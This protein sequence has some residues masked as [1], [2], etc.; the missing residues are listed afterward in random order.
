MNDAAVP[1]A[2]RPVCPRC[3]TFALLR[4]RLGQPL[5]GDCIER[6]THDIER[7]PFPVGST[8][9]GAWQLVRLV[10]D[11][12]L[13][14][15]LAIHLP[16]IVSS[17]LVELPLRARGLFWI[18]ELV[19]TAAIVRMAL[20]A[21]RGSGREPITRSIGAAVV[22]WG[23]RLVG[24]SFVSALVSG[25]YLLLLVV[26]GVLKALSFALVP[27]C[28]VEERKTSA[29]ALERST[30]LMRG[31]RSIMF[32]VWVALAV[33]L[34]ATYGLCW[35][36]EAAIAA[37]PSSGAVAALYAGRIVSDGM[38]VFFAVLDTLVL[39]VVYVKL[40]RIEETRAST[41]AHS[42]R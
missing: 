23:G 1:A 42:S 11:R 31:H 26:P 6:L 39:V 2:D 35:A 4:P 21:L 41:A 32:A 29:N 16:R 14:I 20:E 33:P 27:V 7:R 5:C 12:A 24:A 22:V 3:G 25:F 8:L 9:V 17:M 19:A 38:F 30:E 18:L 13:P 10:G 34:Y 36:L 15:A 37:N 28:V 40:V